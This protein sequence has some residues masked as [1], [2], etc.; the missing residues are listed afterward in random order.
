MGK[1]GYRKYD[2]DFIFQTLKLLAFNDY[3]II[4]TSKTTGIY[5]N[6]I[7]RWREEYEDKYRDAIQE[8]STMIHAAN[9]SPAMQEYREVV[10]T[11]IET[12]KELIMTQMVK[13]IPETRNLDQLSRA[14]KILY[15]CINDIKQDNTKDK[16]YL[17]IITMQI[18]AMN[19]KLEKSNDIDY[20]QTDD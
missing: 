16:S 17:Q 3:N 15:E 5:R 10:S 4:E 9:V 14:Y 13:V 19:G 12:V 20:E 8:S 6:T 1:G 2:M 7:R 11:D 18:N